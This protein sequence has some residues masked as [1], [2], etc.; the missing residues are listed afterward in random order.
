MKKQKKPDTKMVSSELALPKKYRNEDVS[1]IIELAKK[2]K[3]GKEIADLYKVSL[4]S[5]KKHVSIFRKLGYSVPYLRNSEKT[6][7]AGC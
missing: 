2:G 7:R 5:L 4:F 6:E 3:T 1:N